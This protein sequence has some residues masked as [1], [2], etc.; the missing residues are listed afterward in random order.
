MAKLMKVLVD[1]AALQQTAQQ[2]TCCRSLTKLL[3]P[4]DPQMLQP[5]QSEYVDRRFDGTKVGLEG[6]WGAHYGCVEGAAEDTHWFVVLLLQE[7]YFQQLEL[8]STLYI[9]NLSFYT[10]EDQVGVSAGRQAGRLA[11]AHPH[12]VT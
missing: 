11:A 1:T 7:E 4:F 5:L 6:E 10:T 9:G 3:F 8:S 2:H 12:G